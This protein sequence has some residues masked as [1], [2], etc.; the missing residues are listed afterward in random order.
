MSEPLLAVDGLIKRFGG[1]VATDNLS[2]DVERRRTARADRPERRRQ[3]HLHLAAH[4]R[5]APGCGHHPVR[6][7][8]DQRAGRRRR[9]CGTASRASFQITQLLPDYTALD[10]VALAV[11]A[12]Q[13]PPSAS[14]PMRGSDHAVPRRGPAASRPRRAWRPRRYRGRAT[15]RT[16]SRSSSSSRSR[17]RPSRACC[18]STSRWPGS[19]PPNA[20][21]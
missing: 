20:R 12:Q 14:W 18:C 7:R 6:R 16:A 2:L 21:A 1:L 3:D 19:A 5:T 13:R 10:N 9:A 15:C 4:G 11:Q 17:S 8:G